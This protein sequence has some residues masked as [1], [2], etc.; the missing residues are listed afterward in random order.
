MGIQDP[1]LV[2]IVLGA[3]LLWR[4]TTGNYA[5][6]K[7]APVCKHFHQ[8]R[9][10]GVK[11]NPSHPLGSP[12]WKLSAASLPF[13]NR[14]LNWTL[15]NGKEINICEDKILNQSKLV[16]ETSL[17][18]L[19]D[20]L[21]SQRKG[22]LYDIS[23]WSSTR[24]WNGWNLGYIPV[25]LHSQYEQL[26]NSL[27]RLDPIHQDEDEKWGWV[28][29]GYMVARGYEELLLQ[30]IPR[31]RSAFWQIIWSSDCLPKINIFCWTFTHERILTSEN[32]L[33]RGILGPSWCVLC[34]QNTESILHLFLECP[35]SMQFW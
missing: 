1:I 2:N 32:L 21:T 34:K 5:W 12:I 25:R 18:L 14:N 28:D 11:L 31:A 26:I 20:S 33:K 6:W 4:M 8:N 13:F 22:T 16:L 10:R 19:R 15:G 17:L 30:N 7:K 27:S 35:I 3:S 9:K 23:N 24:S 29:Q